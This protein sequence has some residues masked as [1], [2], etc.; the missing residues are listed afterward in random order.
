MQL[1]ASSELKNNNK[2]IINSLPSS[3]LGHSDAILHMEA[4]S[5]RSSSSSN[6]HIP[7]ATSTT[8]TEKNGVVATSPPID[9][10]INITSKNKETTN[11]SKLSP[12]HETAT[13][14][15]FCKPR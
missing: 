14:R 13:A 15:K 11:S 5:Q 1:N 9:D 6:K 7:A 3:T 10:N 8:M 2:E 12:S 4:V